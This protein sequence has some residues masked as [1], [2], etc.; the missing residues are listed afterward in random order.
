VCALLLLVFIAFL[1]FPL[2]NAA[3]TL[4]LFIHVVGFMAYCG[5]LL[6]GS[7]W[8][9]RLLAA[10]LLWVAMIALIYV[11][12]QYLLE[13]RLVVP[14]RVH[15]HVVVVRCLPS[16]GVIRRGDWIAFRVSSAQNYF[17]EGG[18]H[19]NVIIR[20]GITM[21]PVLAVPGDQIEFS[22]ESFS[23]NGLAQPRLVNMPAS[24]GWTVP[25]NC[26]FAWADLARNGYGRVPEAELAAA[27]MHVA[28]VHREQFIG[29]APKH[30]FGR[31]QSFQ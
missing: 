3:F 2:A 7:Y 27:A 25:E 23:V 8:F 29:Q 21:A 15:G 9:N 11:P 14:V 6:A 22:P 12:F 1:G 4:L 17:A 31:R 20:D 24:G 5:P 30:W 28:K 10:L 19:G 13:H 16:P 26:L 18:A